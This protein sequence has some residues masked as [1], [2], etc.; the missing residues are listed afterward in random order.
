MRIYNYNRVRLVSVAAGEGG[1]LNRVD[2]SV[3]ESTN[4]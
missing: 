1:L 3:K 2:I 4:T